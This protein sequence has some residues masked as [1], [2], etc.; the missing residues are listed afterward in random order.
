MQLKWPVIMSF[1]LEAYVD[2]HWLAFE[3]IIRDRLD[4]VVMTIAYFVDELDPNQLLQCL[5]VS[6][7]MVASN[8]SDKL[9]VD[10]IKSLP[11]C[12]KKRRN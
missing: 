5:P 7:S 12:A 3:W 8:S 9:S 1:D 10:A 11:M 4:A 2:G 6:N